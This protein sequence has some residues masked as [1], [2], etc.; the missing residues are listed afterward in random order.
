MRSPMLVRPPAP[1]LLKLL[2]G[3]LALNL[4]A[5]CSVGPHYTRP[6]SPLPEQFDQSLPEQQ[7][8]RSEAVSSAMWSDLGGPELQTLLAR[9]L[10]ANTQIEQ[11]TARLAETRALSGLTVYSLFPT[12]TAGADAERSGSSPADP[13]A[14]PDQANT[15]RYRVG[16]D[17]Q[18]EIDL[19]GSLRNQSDAIFRRLAADQ[20]HQRAVQIAIIAETAQ[21][22]YAWRG[23]EQQM[24]LLDRQIERKQQQQALLEKTLRAGRSNALDSARAELELSRLLAERP[25]IE[26][27]RIRQEQRLA[28]LTAW[29][30]AQLRQHLSTQSDWTLP[31]LSKL[32]EPRDWLLRR[33]DI[34]AAERHLAAAYSDVGYETAQYFPI[35]NLIGD[36]GWT[37][38][39]F[40]A[41]GGGDSQRWSFGPSL[42]W[43]FLDFGRVKQQVKA[44]EARAQGAQALYQETVLKA[45][46]ETENALAQWRAV[47]QRAARLQRAERLAAEAERLAELR[48][49]A[50]ADSLFELLDAQH[51]R[52]SAESETL[53]AKVDQATALVALYKALAGDFA[54]RSPTDAAV[55]PSAGQTND[56]LNNQSTESTDSR[57]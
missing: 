5:A 14:F 10:S 40:G 38:Q 11:A 30:V 6:E 36:F 43:R 44:A 19:F 47:N 53:Q 29:P 17:M 20:A 54:E 22:W 52:I 4:M 25:N 35:L 18:W 2:A 33:P 55:N 28:V 56:A 32:G 45:L 48:Y 42:S 49:Q 46:E 50:G 27:Q 34:S 51:Q 31:A 9:A 41:L 16:F 15:E 12:V 1:R 24:V 57:S 7:A 37:A 13:F 23:A 26:L 39:S 8:V 3:A 21:A